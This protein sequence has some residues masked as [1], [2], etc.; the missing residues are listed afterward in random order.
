MMLQKEMQADDKLF[1]DTD[2]F[3]DWGSK[4]VTWSLSLAIAGLVFVGMV[5]NF[6]LI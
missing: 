4:V 5:I 1:E 6:F 2:N 3:D